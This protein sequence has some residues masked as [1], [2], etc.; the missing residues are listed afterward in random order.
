MKKTQLAILGGGPGGYTAAFLAADLG[1]QVTLIEQEQLGGTCLNRGCIPSKTLLHVA[2]VLRESRELSHFGVEFGSPIIHRESLQTKVRQTVQTLCNGIQLLAKQR[3]VTLIAGRGELLDSH[4]LQILPQTSNS[5]VGA[6]DNHTAQQ[7]TT[8]SDE[9]QTLAFDHLIIATG[10]KVKRPSFVDSTTSDAE[11]GTPAN[12]SRS[13]ASDVM[14]VQNSI[15][16]STE[17]LELREIPPKLLVLGAG[18]VG[19][20]LAA[21]YAALGSRVTIVETLPRILPTADAD[22]VKT[23]ERFYTQYSR[24]RI[25]HQT[26]VLGVRLASRV[27]V[28][29][30]MPCAKANLM[31]EQMSKCKM[32]APIEVEWRSSTGERQVEPF[33]RVISAIGR[34]P[35][36]EGIGLERTRVERRRDGRLEVDSQQRTN[37]TTIFAI[38]DCTPGPM[39]AHRAIHEAKVAVSVIAG[40]KD[41]CFE[42]LAIPN[43]IYADPE[44][45][46]TGLTAEEAAVIGRTVESVV[47]PW[48][49]NGRSHAEGTPCGATKWIFDP[50]SQRVL[51]CGIVGTGASEL[52]G[53]AVLAIEKGANVHELAELIHPHPTRSETLGCAAE[54]QLGTATEVYKP[55]V[56]K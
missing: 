55:R 40:G 18:A 17:A 13:S 33:D 28:S 10:S 22:L 32:N 41:E 19:L 24:V 5:A 16:S 20:E 44:F 48:L 12:A 43:V 15:W 56:H 2:R 38:G 11:I 14:N 29:E 53:E 30:H 47:F 31:A 54:L 46:W 3:R 42:P 36:T 50:K 27:A 7:D 26:E 34:T 51:G 45:A 52:I 23:F 39:L 25:L 1:L 4:T 21:V 37:D 49:A 8:V 9:P 35:C 6:I